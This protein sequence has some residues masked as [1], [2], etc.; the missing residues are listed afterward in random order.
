MKP[1][2]MK[3]LLIVAAFIAAGLVLLLSGLVVGANSPRIIAMLISPTPTATLTSTPTVTPTPT[4][5]ATST[6][7]P[8]S[9]PTITPTYD[10]CPPA[11]ARL[12]REQV[13]AIYQSATAHVY[14]AG[15]NS[16]IDHINALLGFTDDHNRAKSL[17][18]FKC[19][20][21]KDDL[22]NALSASI[23]LVV[24]LYGDDRTN[25]Q[26]RTADAYT[27]YAD[28]WDAYHSAYDLFVQNYV[29]K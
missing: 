7:T 19:G 3:R 1:I 6:L 18:G 25:L 12:L 22:L 2:Q 8:T 16:Q 23:Y 11:R 15:S 29:N 20:T 14:L 17:D 24:T 9:T 10:P 5:T 13:D 28:A 4:A 27:N 26:A 21:V